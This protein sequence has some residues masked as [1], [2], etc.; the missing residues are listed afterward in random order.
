MKKHI[1]II[2]AALFLLESCDLI[3]GTGIEN[4]NLPI[5]QAVNLPNPAAPWVNGLN[6]QIA[7]TY[8]EFLVTAELSTDNYENV[9]TF[10][11]QNVDAG[12][13][14]DVDD[15]FDDT[16]LSIATLREQ[17]AFG[18]ENILPNDENA[19]GTALEAEM[20]FY[21]GLGN[22]LAGELV[23][24]FP[25]EANGEVVTPDQH[26]QI[27]VSDFNNALAV[28]PSAPAAVGYHLAL[29][30][31]YYNL[32][33][34]ANAVAS[35]NNALSANAS[36]DFVRLVE[37]DGVN[38]PT[39]NMQNAVY[40]RANFDDLQ[41]LPR[42]DF[43][44]PKYAQDGSNDSPVPLLKIEEAYLI[45]AEAALADND[46]P[47]AQTQMQNALDVVGNRPTRDFD[48]GAEGRLDPRGDGFQ[49]PNNS[50]F[51]VLFGP[52]DTNPKSGYILD[53]TAS[54][55]VPIISGTSRTAAD[56]TGLSSNLEA[57]E[58]LYLMRQ[59]IFFGEGRRIFDLGIR[60][61]VA[62]VEALNNPNIS[63]NDRQPVIPGYLPSAE[64][65]DGFTINGNTVTM[66]VNLNRILAEQKGNR[67]N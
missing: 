14:R 5:D 4:P 33:D 19:Q 58:T 63:D 57:L 29:A 12:T 40:D 50:S 35:A 41:P 1:L 23:T 51:E 55:T 42:L 48:E 9:Q 7:T 43:L 49:R 37:F 13:Y 54:T 32:G 8:N 67:F 66:S 27:A 36:N 28:T 26:F 15:D 64:D 38:G 62:E 59:E 30:R 20:H 47:E 21:K 2:F 46:L 11:N 34:Q 16:Q 56:I 52:D 44:D 3:D 60:W 45:L 18:L 31:A 25:A 17:A 53:R 22:L 24:A 10:F 6:E 39:S 61:P 65:M